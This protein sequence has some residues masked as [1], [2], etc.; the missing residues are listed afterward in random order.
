MGW[1]QFNQKCWNGNH[2]AAPPESRKGHAVRMYVAAGC[3]TS[4][5]FRE[6]LLLLLFCFFKSIIWNKL[7]N[8][9]ETFC[10]KLRELILICLEVILSP[11]L[12][13]FVK[14]PSDWFLEVKLQNMSHRSA[15]QLSYKA[16]RFLTALNT[17]HTL[18]VNSY[19]LAG[20]QKRKSSWFNK[21]PNGVNVGA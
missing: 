16:G 3:N 4:L 10:Q 7:R 18:C 20:H 8:V 21:R 11:T 13:F 14:L 6:F 12:F 2:L 15:K 9:W 17:A 5:C 19:V 1:C